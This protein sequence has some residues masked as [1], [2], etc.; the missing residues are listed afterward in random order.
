MP[1]M[2]FLFLLLVPALSASTRGCEVQPEVR[3]AFETMER[4]TQELQYA[5]RMAYSRKAYGELLA[6]YPR[7]IAVHRKYVDFIKRG[8]PDAMPALRAKYQQEAERNPQDAFAVY[9]VGY[10]LQEFRTPESLRL[11]EKAKA[12]DPGNP[13]TYITLASLYGGGKFADKA[14]ANENMAGYYRACPASL[15]ALPLQMIGRRLAPE[16]QREIAQGIRARLEKETDPARLK[17]YATL[18]GVEFRATPIPEHAALRKQVAADVQRLVALNAKPDAA[19]LDLLKGGLKQSGASKPAVT[20]VEDR[21]LREFPSSSEALWIVLRRFDEQHPYPKPD[22]AAE[23]WDNFARAFLAALERWIRQFP[24]NEVA[25]RGRMI[26]GQLGARKVSRKTAVE[27]GE[28]LLRAAAL[29]HGPS[30]AYVK[31]QVADFYLRQ[32][33]EPKRALALLQQ[34]EALRR[35]EQAREMENDRLTDSEIKEMQKDART[36]KLYFQTNLLRVSLRLRNVEMARKLQT[37]IGGPVPKD[38]DEAAQHWRNLALF[39]QIEGRKADAL[40]FYQRALQTRPKAPP[41]RYGRVEDP[42]LDEARALWRGMGGTDAA[43]DVWSKPPAGAAQELTQGRWER[44]EKDL[45]PFELTDLTGRKWNSRDLLGKTLF[46]NV[47]ATWCGPC[48]TELPHLQKLYEKLKGRDDV[49]LLSLNVDNQVGIVE[50]FIQEKTFTFP[51]LPAYNFVSSLLD[52]ISI[53]RNWIVDAKGKWQWEQLGFD[54]AETDWEAV[55]LAKIE[56]VKSAK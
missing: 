27:L 40:T 28:R 5:E 31:A 43:W 7:E 10:A 11:V 14:K 45:P 8:T 20:T 22:A 30:N 21:I 6:K 39:A 35:Q 12:L 2:L 29:A 44:P 17:L 9:I 1:A 25:W 18:W 16:A 56:S 42:L 19:W 37:N 23:V 13:W 47:W 33:I 46:I 55:V 4:R 51:V 34:S 50:P 15:E 49:V 48:Q 26:E 54:S 3:Q 52:G 24:L 32:N 53:P 38:R 36:E 41:K